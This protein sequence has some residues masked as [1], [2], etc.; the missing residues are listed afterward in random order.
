MNHIQS[1]SIKRKSQDVSLN[2]YLS[3]PGRSKKSIEQEMDEIRHS[4]LTSQKL[5][6]DTETGLHKELIG[7][8]E[9]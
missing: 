7:D 9:Q 8:I 5:N 2:D 4:D 3:S 1:S 6:L